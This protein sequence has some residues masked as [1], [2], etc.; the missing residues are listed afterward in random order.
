MA[1]DERPTEEKGTRPTP[2]HT[3]FR[4]L[5]AFIAEHC[6]TQS[7]LCERSTTLYRVYGHW[8]EAKGEPILSLPAFQQALVDM[9]FNRIMV[10]GR[11]VFHG[12]SLSE[13]PEGENQPTKQ[14]KCSRCHGTS[15]WGPS[16]MYAADGC[17]V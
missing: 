17:E 10:E 16:G 5:E 7:D 6:L 2:H 4:D 3:A 11:A 15:G 13:P 8:L 9:E 14:A 12:R 1:H